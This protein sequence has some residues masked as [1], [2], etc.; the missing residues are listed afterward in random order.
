MQYDTMQYN[1]I[2]QNY[3]TIQFNTTMQYNLSQWHTI[4]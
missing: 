2:V 3:K 1:T 4:D